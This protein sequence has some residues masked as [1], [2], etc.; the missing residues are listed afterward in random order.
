LFLRPRSASSFGVT[1]QRFKDTGKSG[2]PLG[3]FVSSR[4][5]VEFVRNAVPVQKR[6]KFAVRSKKT[7]PLAAGEIKV[8]HL[9]CIRAPHQNKWIIIAARVTSVW[10]KQVSESSGLGES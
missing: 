9:A 4:N 5:D 3:P 1:M 8:R 10:A 7:F 6:C 2:I